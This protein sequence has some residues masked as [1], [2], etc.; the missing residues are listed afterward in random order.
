M[1]IPTTGRPARSPGAA[2]LVFLL[3]AAVSLALTHVVAIAGPGASKA[4]K[5]VAKKV[6]AAEKAGAKADYN[7][8]VARAMLIDSEEERDEALEE[9][10]EEYGDAKEIA[11]DAYKARLELAADLE[12]DEVYKVEIDP[13]DFVAGVTHPLMP[14]TPGVT[15]TYEAETED[16]TETIVVTVL[17]ETREIL[18]VTCVVVRDTVSIDGELVEDTHDWFAQDKAGNVW[19]FGEISLNYE[20]GRLVDVEGSW[21]AGVDGARPGIVMPAAPAVGQLYRQEFYLGEA[22]D[23]AEVLALSET[24]TVPA[25]TY[26]GCLKTF[27]GT[28]MEPDVEENKY[29]A[30]GVGVVLEVDLESGERVELISVSGP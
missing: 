29:Y 17:D 22:E 2:L 21:E 15:R 16:G 26:T 11:G 13:A 7:L 9:A 6:K 4:W 1:S 27:D 30:P 3:V 10:K 5:K 18:G 8:A 20:D 14:L 12:E 19:Y 28:P 23:Y 25:G 24:V